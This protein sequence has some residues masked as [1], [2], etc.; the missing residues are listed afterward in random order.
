MHQPAKQTLLRFFILG[1]CLLF[2]SHAA[3]VHFLSRDFGLETY[4]FLGR[5]H[6]STYQATVSIKM[7]RPLPSLRTARMQG[8]IMITTNP[9]KSFDS[10]IKTHVDYITHLRPCIKLLH[11]TNHSNIKVSCTDPVAANYALTASVQLDTIYVLGLEG[12]EQF[13][14][15]KSTE[16]RV[17]FKAGPYIV[18]VPNVNQRVATQLLDLTHAIYYQLSYHQELGLTG[19][20][21]ISNLMI[22]ET[23]SRAKKLHAHILAGSLVLWAWVS[24]EPGILPTLRPG[25]QLMLD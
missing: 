6:G 15:L 12:S 23:L 9:N 7:L 19:M 8:V 13:Y 20:I 14:M 10:D 18:S 25:G 4:H 16:P 24:F 3:N 21:V 5:W 22:I 11:A 17:S 2:T 1:A